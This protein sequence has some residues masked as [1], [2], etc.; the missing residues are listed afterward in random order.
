MKIYIWKTQIVIL[1]L[2]WSN[3]KFLKFYK[4]WSTSFLF[5]ESKGVLIRLC[6]DIMLN[7]IDSSPSEFLYFLH[8]FYFQEIERNWKTWPLTSLSTKMFYFHQISNMNYLCIYKF[9]IRWPWHRR[10]G[11][12]RRLNRNMWS[13]KEVMHI[14]LEEYTKDTKNTYEVNYILGTFWT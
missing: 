13:R 12:C 3:I 11:K 6:Q 10:K 2:Q 8:F 5:A 1:V 4:I 14:D 7:D 9:I